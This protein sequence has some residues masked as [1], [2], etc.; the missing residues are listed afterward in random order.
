MFRVVDCDATSDSA[1]WCVQMA[2]LFHTC[3]LSSTLARFHA[4]AYFG[5]RTPASCNH[6]L[7][8]RR[9]F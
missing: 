9:K 3:D 7:L 1:G 2:M 6:S 4:H 8:V 5:A